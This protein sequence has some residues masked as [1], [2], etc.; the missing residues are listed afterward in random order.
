MLKERK[1]GLNAIIKLVSG[2]VFDLEKRSC[3]VRAD[4]LKYYCV[5]EGGGGGESSKL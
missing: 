4:V 1:D 5:G 3:R 2:D